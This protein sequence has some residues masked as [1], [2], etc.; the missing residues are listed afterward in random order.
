MDHDVLDLALHPGR[1]LHAQERQDVRREQDAGQEDGRGGPRDRAAP[2]E[3]PEPPGGHG[4]AQHRA[5]EG[6]IA[7]GGCLPRE[8]QGCGGGG[9]GPSGPLQEPDQGQQQPR[10]TADRGEVQVRQV[11]ELVRAVGHGDG[12]HQRGQS[13]RAQRLRQPPQA[14]A[15]Q[16]QRE[17][18]GRVV[19]QDRV[20]REGQQRLGQHGEP[21]ER[22]REEH[23]V[24]R[25][26]EDVA[27]EEPGRI[28][29]EVC[30]NPV[31]GP[32]V[33]DRVGA[34][35][36]PGAEVREDPGLDRGHREEAEEGHG[37]DESGPPV[38]VVEGRGLR[39]EPRRHDG[40]RAGGGQG[41]G[42]G[43]TH[44]ANSMPDGLDRWPASSPSLAR[45]IGRSRLSVT[46]SIEL[47]PEQDHM[48]L[49]C[50]AGDENRRLV[51]Y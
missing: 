51:S 7:A 26:E 12:R 27:L 34:R 32:D 24:A 19:E 16:R 30:G 36:G 5:G 33:D 48:H 13:V 49:R 20:G 38:A 42:G 35:E 43:Q 39:R 47:V 22:I 45:T 8:G 18:D 50:T 41:Q 40:L 31:E 28:L 37:L 3:G 14:V 17:Q 23:G 6:L 44:G 46:C 29:Q 21:E 2:R 9:G 10:Q 1:G 15:G 4:Q 11:V 25:G